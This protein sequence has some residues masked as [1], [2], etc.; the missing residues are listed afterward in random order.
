MLCCMPITAQLFS[1]G[2]GCLHLR[3]IVLC[4][5]GIVIYINMRENAFESKKILY[6]CGW[7]SFEP[8]L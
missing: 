1:V 4:L 2:D 6:A 3:A 7:S 5:F 8:R